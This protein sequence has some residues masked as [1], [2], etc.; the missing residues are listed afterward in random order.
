MKSFNSYNLK[1]LKFVIII[2][3]FF[4]ISCTPQYVRQPDP[5][6]YGLASEINKG[7][8]LE[9]VV[10]YL[11]RHPVFENDII[12]KS[13]NEKYHI[14]VF[15]R[16]VYENNIDLFVLTFKNSKL[17]YWENLDEYKRCDD[18]EINQLG[19]EISNFLIKSSKVN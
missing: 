2:V 13:S 9:K 10:D 17:Y 12:L 4:T 8:S 7:D 15:N 5:F 3:F 14:L 6:T 19:I 1:N 18:T 11:D 16:I